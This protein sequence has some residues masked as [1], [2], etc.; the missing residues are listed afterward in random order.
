MHP[1]TFRLRSPGRESLIS[2]RLLGLALLLMLAPGSGAASLHRARLAYDCEGGA[3]ASVALA[4]E[5]EG[6]RFRADNTSAQRV[7]V[8]VET[9]AGKSS[10]SVEPRRS[11]YLQVKSFNGPYRAEFE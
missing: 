6:Q 7:R 4:W 9:S 3:C 5:E 2:L 10:V 8:E 11:E 1:H